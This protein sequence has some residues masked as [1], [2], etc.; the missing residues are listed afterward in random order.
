MEEFEEQDSN[1]RPKQLDFSRPKNDSRRPSSGRTDKA[2]KLR[3]MSLLGLLLL[4][5]V[6][7][8]EAGKP[9]RWMWLGFEPPAD[10][11]VV[12]NDENHSNDIVV[13][14][15]TMA[16]E[17]FD[18]PLHP[19]AELA[20]GGGYMPDRIASRLSSSGDGSTSN[21]LAAE[22]IGPK[23]S[24][25][26]PVAVDFWRATF[27]KLNDAQQQALYQ[28]LRRI[29]T[30]QLTPP[31]IDLPFAEVVERL[32]EL[33]ANH[34]SRILGELATMSKGDP[35][36]ELT[37][38]LFALDRSWQKHALPALKASMAGDDFSMTDQATIRSIR[39]TIDPIVL[40]AVEDM[41]GMGNP[42]DK[43]A[44][45]AIWDSVQR[46]AETLTVKHDSATTL[47]QLK[48]QPHA[49]RG[50]TITITGTARTIRRRI[51]KQTLLNL[52][53]YYELWIDPPGRV[54]DGLI[55]VY[56]AALPG[57]FDAVDPVLPAVTEK[58]QTV[59]LPVTVAGRFFKLRSY[60]DA[61]KSVSHCP[62]V[63]S[64]TFAADFKNALSPADEAAA[65]WQPSVP[66]SF[67]FLAM[68][69]LAAVG[70]AYAVFRSTHSGTQRADQP[71][72]RRV[73]RSL[74]ALA[75]DETVM[76]DAQR[77]AALNERL[78]EDFS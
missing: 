46:D 44:W 29:D 72:S 50:Q 41:T 78:E 48:G 37:E 49:F 73:G 64:E 6:A 15:Q 54:N 76:T 3:L 22:P 24:Q 21:E 4:V 5:I 70:I 71:I 39:A 19:E 53:H 43:L 16:V 31:K 75:D 65:R 28:L 36:D 25:L 11:A 57:G 45:L 10:S 63:I 52:D 60:Q 59:R 27:S 9:E 47:L 40:K 32:I 26:T 42:R 12:T 66:L 30:A 55:C 8:K 69:A 33:Q 13:R 35:K 58:F 1:R 14:A 34:Q 38:D 51:P 67:A 68:A 2:V 61:S 17:S 74:E 77:V 7:M 18:D 56:A 20:E 23:D 62:V